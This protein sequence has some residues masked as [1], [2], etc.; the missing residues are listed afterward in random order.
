PPKP[1]T[2]TNALNAGEVG[3]WNW[4]TRDASMKWGAGEG[5]DSVFWFWMKMMVGATAGVGVALQIFGNETA[6]W[7]EINLTAKY[8]EVFPDLHEKLNKFEK[9]RKKNLMERGLFLWLDVW[10]F[11]LPMSIVSFKA[12]VIL[13]VLLDI[14]MVCFNQLA[15]LLWQLVSPSEPGEQPFCWLV[16]SGILRFQLYFQ[17]EEQ[18]VQPR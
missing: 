13:R 7:R 5:D 9:E 14:F 6:N 3:D 8:G 4:P 16:L 2:H 17:V 10:N 11:F 12:I 1:V 15:Q 18:L